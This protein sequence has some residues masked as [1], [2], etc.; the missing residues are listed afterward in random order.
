MTRARSA[1]WLV[2]AV[3]VAAAIA[4]GPKPPPPPP[5]RPSL[6]PGASPSGTGTP[7]PRL[8]QLDIARVEPDP[9]KRAEKLA[10]IAKGAPP[11]DPVARAARV[12]LVRTWALAGKL[13][14]MHKAAGDLEIADDSEGADLLNV[15]AYAYADAGKSLERAHQYSQRALEVVL[16]LRRPDGMPAESWK[17]QIAAVI[18]AYRDTL[19]WVLFKGGDFRGA[20][21]EIRQAA[22]VLPDDPTINWHLGQALLAAGKPADAITALV[23]SAVGEGDESA[24]A[25]ALALGSAEKA[26]LTAADIEK[27][28]VDARAALE[29]KVK[30]AAVAKTLIEEPKELTSVDASGAPVRIDAA[31][32]KKPVLLLFWASFSTP[33]VKALRAL[34]TR[35]DAASSRLV[36]VSL[37]RDPAAATAAVREVGLAALPALDPEGKEAEAF[38]VRGLPT[39]L[40]LDTQGRVRYRNEG[41][42]PGYEIQLKAQLESLSG[43]EK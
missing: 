25:K 13:D 30:A 39:V 17:R 36:T 43:E 35:P 6:D 42:G 26:G 15:M 7:D 23:R 1:L 11:S 18:A 38:Q 31:K 2:F 34:A 4:C 8:K 21:R 3:S 40:V 5:A 22:E 9:V 24:P 19:G 29:A 33:S 10:A 41:M 32:E 14:E 16:S 37:D 27:K 20:V 28:V 12:A